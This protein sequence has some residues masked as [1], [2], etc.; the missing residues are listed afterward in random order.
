MARKAGGGG[1]QRPTAASEEVLHAVLSDSFPSLLLKKRVTVQ[2]AEEVY[3]LAKTFVEKGGGTVD[4]KDERFARLTRY[5][6]KNRTDQGATPRPRKLGETI[7]SKVNRNSQR[8]KG[9]ARFSLGPLDDG[10]VEWITVTYV[11]TDT[12]MVKKGRVR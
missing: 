5:I 11:D 10:R 1:G 12:I 6:E 8:T 4:P 2:M 9:V 7:F 3:E